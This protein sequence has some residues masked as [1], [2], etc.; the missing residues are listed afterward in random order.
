M[1]TKNVNQELLQELLSVNGDNLNDL[2]KV[3]LYQLR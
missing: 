2:E 1:K 3:L